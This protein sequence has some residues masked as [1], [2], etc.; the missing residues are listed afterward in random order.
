M[1]ARALGFLSAFSTATITLILCVS[2]SLPLTAI[3]EHDGKKI[4][5]DWLQM[6]SNFRFKTQF[7]QVRCIRPIHSELCASCMPLS[8]LLTFHSVFLASTD[9]NAFAFSISLSSLLA[10]LPPLPSPCPLQVGAD[11]DLDALE[12]QQPWL[13]DS[14]LVV[15]VDQLV[16]RRGKSGLL[17]LDCSWADAKKWILERRGKPATVGLRVHWHVMLNNSAELFASISVLM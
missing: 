5:A 14:R 1:L 17:K 7:V 9:L 3:R 13:K 12:K 6:H 2:L 11:T 8:S 15:K 10:F 16:K 4:L